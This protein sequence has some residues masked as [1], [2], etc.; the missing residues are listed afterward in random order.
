[1][2]D[3]LVN[4]DCGKGMFRR[5]IGCSRRP[6]ETLMELEDC[7]HAFRMW[8]RHDGRVVSRVEADTIRAPLTTC[9]GAG[10][11]LAEFVGTPLSTTR[12]ELIGRHA[13]GR[14]CTHLYDMLLISLWFYQQNKSSCVI[15]AEVDDFVAGRAGARLFIDSVLEHDWRLEQRL[16]LEPAHLQGVQI[17]P[18]FFSRIELRLP[19]EQHEPALW[20]NTAIFVAAG[21]RYD[22]DAMAGQTVKPSRIPL[23]SCYAYQ[24]ER[25]ALARRS[26]GSVRDFS[27]R[28]D[29]LL[30][31]V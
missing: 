9:P 30:W 20:L 26:A 23:G 27:A 10:D 5:R 2:D 15:D 18:G 4:P 19:K 22:I 11:L 13:K 7:N 3:Y 8:I 12:V 17:G 6:G 31:F 29:R 14:H 28:P 25:L 21:R 24:A 1:M 16:M